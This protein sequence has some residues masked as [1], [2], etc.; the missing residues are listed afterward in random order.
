MT[1]AL[2]TFGDPTVARHC[3]AALTWLKVRDKALTSLTAHDYVQA[4]GHLRAIQKATGLTPSDLCD[5]LH[6]YGWRRRHVM[7]QSTRNT[8]FRM[9][10]KQALAAHRL[11]GRIRAAARPRLTVEQVAAIPSRRP[12][13]YHL[14]M[15][16]RAALGHDE[17]DPLEP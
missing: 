2:K 8:R 6:I 9:T 12:P 5:V 11:P 4:S 17:I 1:K 3:R 15:G 13:R 14:D 7:P 16:D 10:N